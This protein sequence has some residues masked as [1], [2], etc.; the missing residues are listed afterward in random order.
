MTETIKEELAQ[1]RNAVQQLGTAWSGPTGDVRDSLP[2]RSP[3]SVAGSERF[4]SE[5]IG[6][7]QIPSFQATELDWVD[8]Y[9]QR[10]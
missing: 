8:D 6:N 2:P 3:P 7:L 9:R 1:V 4:L 5:T 10:C